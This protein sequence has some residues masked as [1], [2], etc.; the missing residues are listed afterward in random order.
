MAVLA[1]CETRQDVR[2]AHAAGYASAVVA[3]LAEAEAYVTRKRMSDGTRYLWC[4]E[5]S[6][7]ARDCVSC[8]LCFDDQRLLRERTAIVFAAHGA[9]S[10]KVLNVIR[11]KREGA[12]MEPTKQTTCNECGAAIDA[13]ADACDACGEG[14]CSCG[15]ASCP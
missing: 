6:G 2:Q 14:R 7:R 5:Q 11:E 12:E 4:P 13:A 10:R 15:G 8:R 3:P 9:G 1:S